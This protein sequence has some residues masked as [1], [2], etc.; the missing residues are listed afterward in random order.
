[1]RNL[2]L[3][4]ATFFRQESLGRAEEEWR[5]KVAVTSFMSEKDD[6][7]PPRLSAAP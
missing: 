5:K 3:V 7:G 1:M 6:L 4:T 2:K